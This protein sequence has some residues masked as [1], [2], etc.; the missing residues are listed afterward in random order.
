MLHIN[1]LNVENFYVVKHVF[2]NQQQL[3]ADFSDSNYRVTPIRDSEKVG[4]LSLLDQ[5][6]F[7]KELGELCVEAEDD[8]LHAILITGA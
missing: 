2:K 8:A 3:G 7:R 5:Y 6:S 1:V 4:L